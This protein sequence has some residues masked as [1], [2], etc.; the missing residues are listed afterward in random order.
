MAKSL[1]TNE[2]TG[3]TLGAMAYILWAL[4]GQQDLRKQEAAAQAD[5]ERGTKESMVCHFLKPEF[6]TCIPH[7]LS[8][9]S[10]IWDVLS[11]PIAHVHILKYLQI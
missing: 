4:G 3:R 5:V 7:S 11:I 9:A 6:R 2:S 1:E 10:G 8:K